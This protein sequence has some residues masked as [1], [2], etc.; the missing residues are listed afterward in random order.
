MRKNRSFFAAALLV[1][2]L[3][4]LAVAA[5]PALAQPPLVTF[6]V[7]TV[8]DAKDASPGDGTCATAGAACSLRAAI[9]EAQAL[10]AANDYQINI[11]AGTYELTLEA[12]PI[13]V[14]NYALYGGTLLPIIDGR[15]ITFVGAGWSTTEIRR[16]FI[17][18]LGRLFLAFNSNL[19]FQNLSFSEGITTNV[20]GCLTCNHGALINAS[21]GSLAF[22]RVR[23]QSFGGDQL[24]SVVYGEN[25][26]SV[27][28]ARSRFNGPGPAAQIAT[29]AA[30][31]VSITSSTLQGGLIGVDI[32][33]PSSTGT[34][35]IENT[36]LSSSPYAVQVGRS[37]GAG[38]T[39][40]VIRNT[41]IWDSFVRSNNTSAE[42][43]TMRL[44]NSIIAATSPC[45]SSGAGTTLFV[46]EG[47]NLVGFNGSLGGCPATPEFEVIAGLPSTVID[48]TLRSLAASGFGGPTQVFEPADNSPAIDRALGVCPA[49]DGRGA[50][51]SI[52]A[53]C[54]I[55]AVEAIQATFTTNSP[56]TEGSGFAALFGFTGAAACPDCARTISV[57]TSDG[58]AIAPGDYLPYTLINHNVAGVASFTVIGS[59]E[60]D[61]V[62]EPD[63]TFS[64]NVTDTVGFSLMSPATRT[65]TISAN[66]GSLAGVTVSE[67]SLTIEEGESDIFTVVLDAAPGADVT[68]T[69]TEPA[70][71]SLDKTLLTFTEGNWDTPQVVTVTG[72]EDSIDGSDSV[73]DVIGVTVS[74]SLPAY[75]LGALSDID[76]TIT[77]DDV[78]AVVF[79]PASVT[80]VE[81]GSTVVNVTLA[82]LPGGDVTV[83]LTPPA[84]VTFDVSILTFTSGN[85][86]TPQAVTVSGVDNLVDAPDVV[87]TFAY[88]A[89]SADAKYDAL[90][91]TVDLTVLDDDT[92][93]VTIAPTALNL[94]EG[95]S[96]TFDVNLTSQPT[97]DVQITLTFDALDLDVQPNV[98]TFSDLT[99]QTV[100]VTAI[101]DPV[102]DSET[103]DVTFT[104]SSGDGLYDGFVVAPVGVQIT[105]SQTN[106]L[107]NPSFEPNVLRGDI[108]DGWSG[109][110][111]L[112][113]DGINSKEVVDGVTTFRFRF[114]GATNVTRKL[115]Q[116]VKYDAAFAEAGDALAF[117]IWA[118]G[119]DLTT[120]GQVKVKVKYADDNKDKVTL[121]VGV[122]TT[123]YTELTANIPL[124]GPVAKVKVQIQTGSLGSMWVDDSDLRI[125]AAVPRRDAVLPPPS[126][127]DSFRRND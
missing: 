39:E 79:D 25:V 3:T 92:A 16:A 13:D 53:G 8:I 17:P 63:E 111:L 126:A 4:V 101:D 31:N 74:S 35:V 10:G 70:I 62:V 50:T 66:D 81:S 71:A 104:A 30:G 38:S 37:A 108:P 100:T 87:T 51:R 12:Y 5:V 97:A 115:K 41:T 106:L 73:A 58:S 40:V 7:D 127:P 44:I 20:D 61:D 24:L 98:L 84:E 88:D 76:V 120:G 69:L 117:S 43:H 95:T 22:D 78:S 15:T 21:G 93:G 14:D 125:T 114:T 59:I 49:Q 91:G 64:V 33:E 94:L 123:V 23:A 45:G 54:D 56:V 109:K 121:D 77:D 112:T 46:G 85:W 65:Y 32:A 55:G 47:R 107:V 90:A 9:E 52:G 57:A 89:A 118:R 19:T 119:K 2:V 26:S 1:A 68:V 67:S 103:V 11:P 102:I 60:D 75:D 6:N 83:T 80:V 27:S 96:A 82:T 42:T 72:F 124:T 86:D 34:Y 122:G 18:V 116:T 36:T 48:T 28:V 110:D 105:D 29:V 113:S 99:P